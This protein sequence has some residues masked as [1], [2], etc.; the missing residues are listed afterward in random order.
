M[1]VAERFG[2]KQPIGASAEVSSWGAARVPPEVVE[3]VADVLPRL[4]DMLELQQKACS[5]IRRTLGT[6]AG[7][8]TA[9]AASAIVIGVAACMTGADMARVEQLPDAS[10]L[11]NET[12]LQRGHS[13]WFGASARQ[14]IRLAGA[15]VVEIGDV[16][17]AGVYQL[18]GAIGERTAAALFVVSHHAAEYGMIA[19]EDFCRT[20]RAH[21]VPVIVDAASESDVESLLKC[22]PDL[23]CVSGHKYLGGPT[24]G[25]LAGRADLVEAALLHQYYGIGRAMKV[26]KEG[27]VG[28]MCALERW[29]KRD[30]AAHREAQKV[31]ACALAGSLTDLPGVDVSTAPN[32]TGN[33]TIGVRLE[34]DER[35]AGLSALDVAAALARGNPPIIVRND[36]AIERGVLCL[37]L[38]NV[39]PDEIQMIA[40]GIREV[41]G[42][43]PEAKRAIR[44]RRPQLMNPADTLCETIA[45]WVRRVQ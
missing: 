23:L 20:A 21:R 18:A 35:V 22:G 34:V 37:D 40:V 7:C 13:A 15:T 28:V 5:V 33:H 1:N 12:I 25:I 17:R 41:V 30:H 9:C 19:L 14:M 38:A 6:E 29:A 8:V 11:K 36:E 44:Q 10:R 24:S 16:K 26:G 39:R 31:L 3:A 4:V 43:P 27:I 42:L 2:L 45:G 32:Y